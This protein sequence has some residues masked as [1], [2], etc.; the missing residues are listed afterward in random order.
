MN[1]VLIV[2]NTEKSI[3]VFIDMLSQNSYDEIV[4]VKNC[5]EARRLFV[6]RDFDLCIINT[7]LPDEFGEKLAYTIVSNSICQVILVVRAQ[8]YEEVTEKVED[9]GIYTIAKP[10]SKNIFW[11]ALKLSNAAFHKMKQLKRE[12]N[13]LHQ[14]IHDIKFIDRAKWLLIEHMNLSEQ[15]AH[16]YI[17]KQAMD[18]RLTKKEVAAR[19][20][21]QYDVR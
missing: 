14:K 3:A 8:I 5:G 11:S 16:R 7:P 15:E 10:I 2:S 21:K 1:R 17:E 20:M 9:L 12:N 13:K 18:Q 4:T 6:E 19:V